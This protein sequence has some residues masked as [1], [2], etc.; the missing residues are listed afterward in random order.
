MWRGPAYDSRAPLPFERPFLYPPRVIFARN[1]FRSALALLFAIVQLAAAAAFPIADGQLEAQ[2][3]ASAAYAHIEAHGTPECPRVHLENCTLC[4]GLHADG[5]RVA[6]GEAP[7]GAG[8][9]AA[10]GV[11]YGGVREARRATGPV[12]LRGPPGATVPRPG[13]T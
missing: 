3:A 8:G 10:G 6:G 9:G 13:A 11:P 5:E 12:R 7:A 2:A 4:R 1:R